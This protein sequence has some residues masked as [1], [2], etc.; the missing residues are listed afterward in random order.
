MRHNRGSSSAP[1]GADP[2]IGRILCAVLLVLVGAYA[3]EALSGAQGGLDRFFDTWVY[4]GLLLVSSGACL[5]RGLLVRAERLPWLLLGT[6]LLLWT[7][8]DLYYLAFLSDLDEIPIPS[9]SDPF[10]LAFY[11]VSYVAFAL[12]LR[13]RIDRFRGNL[14]LDGVIASLAVAALGAAVVFDN[15]ISTTGGSPLVVATNLA[16][17]LADLLLL[18]LV[19]ATFALTGWRFDRTWALV[20][21]GFAVFAVSDSIYL[22]ETAAGTYVE[23]GLLDVGWPAALVLIACSAWQPR[24]KLEGVRTESWQAL[25]LPTFFAAIGLGLLVYDHFDPVNGVAFLLATAT[26]AAVIVRTVLAFRERVELLAS[27]REEALTDSLTGLGNRRR[28]VADLESR[29]LER[30]EDPIVLV[31]LDLD[32]FKTYNDSFGHAAGDALLGRVATRLADAIDGYGLAYRLGG[33]EFCL[34]AS[35][36]TVAPGGLIERAATALTEEGDGFSVRCS[37]GSVLLPA[38]A[39]DLTEAL[40]IADDRMYLHKQ[41]NRPSAE[42][43]SIEALVASQRD[44]RLVSRPAGVA[45]LAEAVSR[46]LRMPEPELRTLR[47]AAELHDVG[48]LAIPEEILNKP[49]PLSEDEWEF[50][51]RHPLIGERIL[52]SAPALGAAGKLVR[53]THEQWDGTGYPDG[54]ASSEI[55]LGARII[56]VCDSFDAMTSPRPYAEPISTQQAIREL[57]RCA[58][59]QFDPEVVDAFAAVQADLIAQLVA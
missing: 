50:V 43:Q 46:R 32:G 44:L 28:F 36:A 47:Q 23:G 48:K 53:S 37:H 24:V 25:T 42:R 49:G 18:A 19:V 31:V 41:G 7:A 4:N 11:P 1:G 26:I 17:P 54:L 2:R 14:W 45:V 40:R 16:Y 35:V 30:G 12:L 56:A 9:I 52:G 6:A 8:G 3:V 20:A 51:R 38:E 59:T 57:V 10:Y 39:S 13:A 21:A 22:Y 34:L 55:P 5:A 33:D 27:S 29:L 15:V 58:G